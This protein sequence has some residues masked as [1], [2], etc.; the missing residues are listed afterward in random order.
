MSGFVGLLLVLGFLL[1]NV[2]AASLVA[3]SRCVEEG[4]TG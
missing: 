2:F 4:T 1:L 3:S